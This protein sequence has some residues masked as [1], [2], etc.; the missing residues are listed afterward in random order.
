MVNS[1]YCNAASFQKNGYLCFKHIT[2][3]DSAYTNVALRTKNS[4][5]V[6]YSSDPELCYEIVNVR[7]S[8]ETFFSEDCED[9]RAV[10]F[11]RDLVGCSDCVG[12]SNLRKKNYCIF[13]E[14]LTKDE[15]KKRFA[16]FDFGSAKNVEEFGKR[17]QAFFLK[18]PRR[19][20]HGR[21]NSNVSGE[22][23][24]NSKNAHDV[25]FVADS[26]NICY[27]QLFLKGGT[28]NSY[29]FT[30]FG[31]GSEWVYEATWTGLN[32]NN[33]RFSVWNYRNHDTE[34]TFGCHGCGNVFGCVGLKNAEYCVFN[35][36]YAKEEYF[37]LVEK[38]KKQMDVAPFVDR[39]GREHRYGGQFP[40][41]L[42]PWTYNE[43]TAYEFFPITK[44][45]ALA[46]GFTWRDPDPREYRDAT[47]AVPDHIK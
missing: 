36:Q 18:F 44:E 5:D 14:Q 2:G 1:E 15:Y 17:A 12:C 7:R 3:E 23:I 27:A 22:Y 11:S 30:A 24:Y 33:V 40:I 32:T 20:L 41:D 26:E 29:D 6:A 38:I 46:K 10:Y 43:T 19:A 45:E 9:C 25:Y 4:L 8:Y 34:Y 16:E 28:K 42:C 35:K 31:S 13:N 47:I 21:N 37:P 39:L